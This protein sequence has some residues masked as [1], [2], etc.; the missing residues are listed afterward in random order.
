MR[1]SVH[2]ST[3][4]VARRAG[5]ALLAAAAI[6]AAINNLLTG[7]G[8]YR[9]VARA[10]ARYGVTFD[11]LVLIISAAFYLGEKLFWLALLIFCSFAC[12]PR[13]RHHHGHHLLGLRRSPM[14]T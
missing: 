9:I 13:Y 6:D 12:V 4:K 1:L 2:R 7:E 5:R 10:K 8:R 3:D 14:V 11:Q